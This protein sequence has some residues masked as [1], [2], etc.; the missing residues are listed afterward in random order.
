MV[1]IVTCM[2]LTTYAHCNT[3]LR[4]QAREQAAAA[5]AAGAG[6]GTAAAGCADTAAAIM[7]GAGGAGSDSP[8]ATVARTNKANNAATAV[9]AGNHLGSKDGCEVVY[10][11][12]L[13]LGDM[14][15]Y[16]LA[17]SLTYQLNYP[18]I[19]RRRPRLLARWILQ[20]LGTM[21]LMSFMQVGG[22]AGDCWAASTGQQ[23]AWSVSASTAQP[24]SSRGRCMRD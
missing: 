13:S 12:N 16:A 14:A 6:G 8:F 24:E 9:A 1:A 17:P 19:K 18:K 10:P 3:T 22:T 21:L 11:Q 4:R 5:A 7:G 23:V 2:K 15:Y 20:L